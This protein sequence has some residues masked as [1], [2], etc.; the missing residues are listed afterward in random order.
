MVVAVEVKRTIIAR[1]HIAL[2]DTD[3]DRKGNADMSSLALFVRNLSFVASSNLIVTTVCLD[4]LVVCTSLF[5]IGTNLKNDPLQ[6]FIP[7]CVL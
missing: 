4:L 7:Y 2:L 6:P 3:D 1:S 5:Y